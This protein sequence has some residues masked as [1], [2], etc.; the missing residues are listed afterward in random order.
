M[1]AVGFLGF[2]GFSCLRVCICH[3]VSGVLIL[4]VC[5]LFVCL[6]VFGCRGVVEEEEE[7]V[8]EKG[9]KEGDRGR[10]K[11]EEEG[12]GGKEGMR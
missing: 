6:F 1:L 11:G 5:N 4:S 9:E 3:P 10:E 8:R 2:K 12:I 7:R